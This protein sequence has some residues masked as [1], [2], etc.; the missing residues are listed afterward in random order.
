VGF[1]FTWRPCLIWHNA[2]VLF[3]GVLPRFCTQ[4]FQPN[5]QKIQEEWQQSSYTGSS[6]PWAR[7]AHSTDVAPL[8]CD[9]AMLATQ[10]PSPAAGKEPSSIS[11]A[12]SEQTGSNSKAR[13][14]PH[15]TFH[16]IKANHTDSP[17][18]LPQQ[19][20]RHVFY[21]AMAALASSCSRAALR[22]SSG[23]VVYWLRGALNSSPVSVSFSSR[24]SSN[25]VD[26]L[27]AS[28]TPNQHPNHIKLHYPGH[29]NLAASTSAA[30]PTPPNQHAMS[31]CHNNCYRLSTNI[32]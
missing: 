32:T 22:F 10:S 14:P 7:Q 8:A 25:A 18:P 31:M 6:V 29:S 19:S 13:H 16:L 1:P 12:T 20:T 28:R 2:H 21:T 17:A 4:L 9:A 5:T 3:V 15:Q 30:Q 11:T 27:P 26:S 24:S 23:I